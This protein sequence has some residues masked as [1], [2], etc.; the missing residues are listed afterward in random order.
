MLIPR[1]TIRRLLLL[2]FACA[3]VFWIVSL[4]LRGNP[5][6]LA[7]TMLLVGLLLTFL[8]FGIF[9]FTTWIVALLLQDYFYQPVHRSPFATEQPPPQI[10]APEEPV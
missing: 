8:I 4:A 9:F 10:I 1:F 6:A 2:C 5:A 3:I 7:V